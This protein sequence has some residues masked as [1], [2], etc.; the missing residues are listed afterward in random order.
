MIKLEN[1]DDEDARRIINKKL[2]LFLM[3]PFMIIGFSVLFWI[4]YGVIKKEKKNQILTYIIVTVLI[5]FFIA[6]PA[7]VESFLDTWK[8]P[9]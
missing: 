5:L 1:N 4:I 9:K 3:L 2:I 7:I 6:H 8:Y